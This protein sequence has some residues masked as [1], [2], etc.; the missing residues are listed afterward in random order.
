MA[1]RRVM[2]HVAALAIGSALALSSRGAG[3]DMLLPAPDADRIVV[4]VHGLRN[5]RGSVRCH[6]YNRPDNFPDTDRTII[7]NVRAVPTGGSARCE[8]D[9]PSRGQAYAVVVHHDEND[10]N[11]F[12]RGL[13]G[14][15]LEGYG[16]SNDVHPILSAPSWQACR[17][18]F[19]GGTSLLRVATQY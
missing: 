5:N 3:A 13:F 15:P 19:A 16:F 9:R 14:R 17:F 10:D 2:F 11:V 8:F 1:G 6:L 12:Q 7:A 4:D 18:Q